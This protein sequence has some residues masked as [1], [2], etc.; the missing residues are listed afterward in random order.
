[1]APRPRR[2]QQQTLP[3]GE[4]PREG[5]LFCQGGRKEPHGEASPAQV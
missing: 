2:Q 1:M 5:R 3:H 4:A